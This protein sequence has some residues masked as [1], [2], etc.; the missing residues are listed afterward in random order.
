MLRPPNHIRYMPIPLLYSLL[1][2]SIGLIT[3]AL[4]GKLCYKQEGKSSCLQAL[5]Q[6]EEEGRYLGMDLLS[7]QCQRDDSIDRKLP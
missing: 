3:A 4:D 6:A 7:M 1:F 2:Y 5:A